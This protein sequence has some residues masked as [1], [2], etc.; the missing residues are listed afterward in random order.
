MLGPEALPPQWNVVRLLRHPVCGR[1]DEVIDGQGATKW[2]R[3]IWDPC[4][5]LR[6][7]RSSEICDDASSGDTGRRSM[8]SAAH[9]A[10]PA[11]LGS[12]FQVCG[13][14]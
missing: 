9:G 6:R 14:D 5:S 10:T 11:A 8:A 12:C 2:A 4:A 7:V 3:G 13:V 1:A